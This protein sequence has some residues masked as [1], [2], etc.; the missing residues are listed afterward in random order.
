[1]IAFD[2]GKGSTRIVLCGA[3]HARE[4]IASTFLMYLADTY[5]LGYAAD[6]QRDGYSFRELLDSVTFTMCRW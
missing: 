4:Y 5:A 2:F 6:A 1:M 3:M